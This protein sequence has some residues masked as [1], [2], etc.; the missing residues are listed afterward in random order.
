MTFKGLA[1]DYDGTLASHDRI[2]AETLAALARARE[3]GVRLILV[4]GRSFFGL[5]RICE[6][7]DLF[8]AV[9]AENGGVIYFPAAGVIRD[10]GPPPPLRLLAEL[11]RRGIYYHAGRVVVGTARQDEAAVRDALA[12]MGVSLDLLYNRGALMLLP[13][14]ISKGSAV[15][16]VIGVL[17]LS[18][19]DVLA[20][21]DAENDLDLFEACGWAACPA[22]AVPE[23]ARRADWVLPGENG[24]A[25]AEAIAGP[26]LDGSLRLDQS[27]RH[28]IPLGWAVETAEPVT[29]PARGVNVLIEGD[30]LSGKSW[31]AGALV[32][33]LLAQRYALCVIDAE[34]DYRV[35][36]RLPG[37]TWE[38]I[39]D[40]A[41]LR[42]A[43]AHLERDPAACVVV[44]LSGAAHLEKVRL[45]EDALAQLGRLRRRLGRPHWVVLDEAHYSL[46]REGVV[47]PVVGIAEKGFCF[48]T[49][50]PSWLRDSVVKS[51]DVVVLARTTLPEE[52]AFLRAALGEANGGRAVPVLR[53]LPDHE[54]VIVQ[55][56]GAAT[57]F[58][59]PPRATTHVRHRT[60]Y[61][62]SSV[63]PQRAFL[64]RDAGGEVVATARSLTEFR[65]VLRAVDGRVLAAHAARGDF[66]RWMRDVFSDRELAAQ[67]RKTEARFT[68]GEIP[69]LRGPIER[70]IASRY[71]P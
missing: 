56:W 21:G 20:L 34:G 70:L 28:R 3:A 30:P 64:F 45:V 54:F 66:S 44:D 61:A 43:L 59:A 24:A 4:T 47:D 65:H 53:D 12:A 26:I 11:D 37:V 1:C 41:S 22:N 7:L 46:H 49:Y 27:P 31:L 71:G 36:M 10:Q 16:Q 40:A 23:L 9:V 62:D 69:D 48:V 19:H 6:R 14:G 15:R 38:E 63:P 42:R 29:V 33:R 32:E 57:T 39:D 51:I 55:P 52:L 18:F 25:V 2:G 13:A 5:T 8:D 67:I 35:L 68:R 58:T 60:K 17:G 50:R